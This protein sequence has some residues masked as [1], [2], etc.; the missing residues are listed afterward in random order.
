MAIGSG[1][2]QRREFAEGGRVEG[3]TPEARFDAHHEDAIAVIEEG[4]GAV[5][6]GLRANRE[7][8]AGAEAADRVERPR[9]IGQ[10][11]DMD[12]EDVG[13]EAG[14]VGQPAIRLG[15]H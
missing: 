12:R 10:G 15:H 14:V 4:E 7:M 8:G 13:T 1:L 2:S 5:D 3:L 6:R 11:F 9:R